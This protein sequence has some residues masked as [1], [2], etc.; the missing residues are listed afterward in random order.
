MK[1][2]ID[3]IEKMNGMALVI[4]HYIKGP[5]AKDGVIKWIKLINDEVVF[6]V[7]S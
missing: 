5:A 1:Q 2:K 3:W 6:K 7:E 4:I